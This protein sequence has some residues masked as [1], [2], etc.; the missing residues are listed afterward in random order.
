MENK[1]TSYINSKGLKPEFHSCLMFE[2]CMR[3]IMSATNFTVQF[4]YIMLQICF[5]S[6]KSNPISDT[7]DKVALFKNGVPH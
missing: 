6:C 7:D 3:G 5:Y 1:E 4:S 2:F